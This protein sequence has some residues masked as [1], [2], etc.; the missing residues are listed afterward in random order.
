MAGIFG[1][2]KWMAEIER[3]GGKVKSEKKAGSARAH[4][5]RG[6]RPKRVSA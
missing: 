2:R 5:L 1:T 4:G 6:K 3:R